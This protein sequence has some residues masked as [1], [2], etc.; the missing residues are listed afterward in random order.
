[1]AAARDLTGF[2][3]MFKPVD[4]NTCRQVAFALRVRIRWTQRG[5]GLLGVDVVTEY[6]PADPA[7]PLVEL[8]LRS[9]RVCGQDPARVAPL[10]LFVVVTWL[11]RCAIRLLRFVCI[12]YL[13]GNGVRVVLSPSLFV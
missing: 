3:E 9:S 1:M 5:A 13:T 7:Y 4:E 6:G 11:K 10:F 12:I 2:R 8:V